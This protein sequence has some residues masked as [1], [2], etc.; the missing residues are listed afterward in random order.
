MIG[1][2]IGFA[3]QSRY[4]NLPWRLK[5]VIAILVALENIESL[6][7]KACRLS[8][9]KTRIPS[10]CFRRYV[11]KFIKPDCLWQASSVHLLL[12]VL[13]IYYNEYGTNM[14]QALGGGVYQKKGGSRYSLWYGQ[15][16]NLDAR[17][18]GGIINKYGCE[19][20]GMFFI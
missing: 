11:H 19:R 13:Y 3:P 12:N 6:K 2:H 15:S 9:V 1:F 7:A 10:P 17:M 18:W 20:E 8:P 16:D 5:Y 4:C 14:L